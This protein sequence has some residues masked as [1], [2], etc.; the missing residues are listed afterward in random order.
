MAVA[1]LVVTNLVPLYGALFLG[2]DV[3][4]ILF[5]Y[6]LE[7]GI[8][9]L[10]N[11]P[12]MGLVMRASG[13]HW[14]PVDI[15]GTIGF[16]VIHYGIFWLVHGMFVTLLTGQFLTGFLDPFTYIA[17]QPEILFAA[18]LLFVSHL[19]SFFV[20]FVGKR[21]Y[22]HTSVFVQAFKPYPRMIVLQLTV[23]LGGFAIWALGQP[24]ALVALLVIFKTLFD[25]I[26]HLM[27]HANAAARTQ[28]RTGPKGIE[29]THAG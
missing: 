3:P 23:I 29:T 28:R 10:L 26:L 19:T 27:A 6:W 8:V 4:T 13:E 7:N 11:I 18:G 1:T 22:R 20:N 12:K 17:S 14:S 25:L 2:W 16:F 5:T 15:F 9:G 24:V 21:E